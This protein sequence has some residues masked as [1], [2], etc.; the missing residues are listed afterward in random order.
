MLTSASK[1]PFV[2]HCYL[3]TKISHQCLCL[4]LADPQCILTWL[5]SKSIDGDIASY[6]RASW[7][8]IPTWKRTLNFKYLD[9]GLLHDAT[10]KTEV[11]KLSVT[12]VER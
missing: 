4:Q 7:I 2:I 5:H 3:L 9:L 12:V 8:R 1:S 6:Y 11:I 10:M